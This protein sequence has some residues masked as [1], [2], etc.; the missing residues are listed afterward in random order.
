[1]T[2]SIFAR[3]GTTVVYLTPE[4]WVEPFYWDMASV[5]GHRYLACFGP[6]ED[7]A[8]PAHLGAYRIDLALLHQ[9][10]DTRL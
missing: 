1:M 5:L 8:V 6:V 3:V 9:V 10:L 2:N 4:G 7:P